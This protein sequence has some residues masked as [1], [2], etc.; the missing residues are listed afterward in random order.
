MKRRI[1]SA[2]CL[3]IIIVPLYLLGGICW[4]MAVG[5]TSIFALKEALDLK[6]SHVSYPLPIQLTAVIC[7]LLLVYSKFDGYNLAFGVS[8]VAMALSFILLLLPT[9]VI[10][11]YTT[12]EAFYLLGVVIFLGTV[13]NTFI[14]FENFHRLILPYLVLI[15]SMTD[16]FSMIIGK[17]IGTHR[18]SS[19]DPDKTI[20]GAIGGITIASIIASFFYIKVIGSPNIPTTIITTIFLSIISVIGDL[21]FNK[22]KRENDLQKFSKIIPGHGG[23]LDRLDS[24]IFTV[25]TYV[26]ILYII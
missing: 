19:A 23:I 26:V 17:L 2:L 16:T 25:L 4:A 20:E 5:I 14:L 15:A 21:I 18:L 24:L 6:A 12:K 11:K 9:L 10:K 3:L 22:I 8:Y 7:L 1:I 13:F